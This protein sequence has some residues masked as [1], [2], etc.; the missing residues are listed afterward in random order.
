M[1]DYPETPESQL[2][3]IAR[4]EADTAM[5]FGWREDVLWLC[6][7]ARQG[8]QAAAWRAYASHLEHCVTCAEDSF[9]AC[10]EG[11]VLRMRLGRDR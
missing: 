9:A 6:A 11:T 5:D 4:L 1:S 3:R 7:L 10:H 8:V 2:A